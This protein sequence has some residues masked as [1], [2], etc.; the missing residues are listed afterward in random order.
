MTLK[1]AYFVTGAAISSLLVCWAWVK[2]ARRCWWAIRH[3]PALGGA[4]FGRD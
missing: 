2:A 1:K 3:V 4:F